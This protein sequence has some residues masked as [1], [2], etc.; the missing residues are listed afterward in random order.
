M[1]AFWSEPI[2]ST[3]GEMLGIFAIYHNK[4]NKPTEAN[5]SFIEQAANLASI[6]VEKS[7]KN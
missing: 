2:R 5:I 3:K 7:Q 1:R 4:V 6:A